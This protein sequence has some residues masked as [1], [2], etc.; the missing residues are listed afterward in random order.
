MFGEETLFMLLL[1]WPWT[2]VDESDITCNEF[3]F[4]MLGTSNSFEDLSSDNFDDPLVEDMVERLHRKRKQMSKIRTK[5]PKKYDESA[6]GLILYCILTWRY[7]TNL[8]SCEATEP[9]SDLHNFPQVLIS[10][11]ATCP[12]K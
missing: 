1:S 5:Q 6:S 10:C 4:G 3:A 11:Q 7:S 8:T 12:A 9:V 2:N